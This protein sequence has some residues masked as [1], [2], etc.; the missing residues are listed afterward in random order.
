MVV[1]FKGGDEISS[2]HDDCFVEVEELNHGHDLDMEVGFFRR[3]I[4]N[5]NF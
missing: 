5:L 3:K 2:T 1:V 4:K